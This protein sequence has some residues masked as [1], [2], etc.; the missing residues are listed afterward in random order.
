[1]SNGDTFDNKKTTASNYIAALFLY[2][3]FNTG[4][5]GITSIL[6]KWTSAH[7]SWNND[8]IYELL[9]FYRKKKK[10]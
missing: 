1:M 10:R 9:E 4:E 2:N 5:I 6:T 8:S 7:I 3:L